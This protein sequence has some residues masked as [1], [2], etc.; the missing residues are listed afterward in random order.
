[1]GRDLEFSKVWF[2]QWDVI[3]MV[4]EELRMLQGEVMIIFVGF[5]MSQ[6]GSE[7]RRSAEAPWKGGRVGGL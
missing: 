7:G 4:A 5:M 3:M 1:M 6:M 2:S